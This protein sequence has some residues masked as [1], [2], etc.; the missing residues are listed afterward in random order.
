MREQHALVFGL[1]LCFAPVGALGG[2]GGDSAPA[3]ENPCPNALDGGTGIAGETC[4]L[5]EHCACGL[6]CLE[7]ACFPWTGDA[8][9]CGCAG[10]TLAPLPPNGLPVLGES[11]HTVASVVVTEIGT[12]A[13]G[14]NVPRDLALN[15]DDPTQLWVICR[16]NESMVIFEGVNTPG[17]SSRVA[18]SSGSAHFMAQPAAFA[19]G[20]PGTMATIHET[21]TQMII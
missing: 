1:V 2:C 19:F 10:G 9:Q 7:S 12:S 5:D 17:Q 21:D 3:I 11:D 18:H 13:D 20:Q 16:G 8:L 14:L 4:T 6:Q 15:P